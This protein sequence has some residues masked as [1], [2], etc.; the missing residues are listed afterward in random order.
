MK[1]ATMALLALAIPTTALAGAAEPEFAGWAEAPG[2]NGGTSFTAPGNAALVIAA[3]R[4]STE[5]QD[6]VLARWAGQFSSPQLCPALAAA[7]PQRSGDGRIVSLSSHEGTNSCAV[8]VGQ[9]AAGGYDI[10]FML[11]ADNTPVGAFAKLRA[12]ITR[13][14]GKITAAPPA[15]VASAQ[16]VGAPGNLQAALAAVPKAN[17]PI[18]LVSR[19]ATSMSGMFVYTVYRH[20]MIFANGYATDSHCYD[21]D[22]AVQSPTP[23]SLSGKPHECHVVRWR[24]AG[25]RYLFDDDDN[26]TFK[27][28]DA[29]AFLQPF[30]PGERIAV[31]LE[32]VSG[33]GSGP[34]I[35]GMVSVNSI[36]S[37]E[38]KMTTAGEIS[39]GSWTSVVVSGDGIGGGANNGR[40]PA[41]GRYLLDGFLIAIATKEGG[42]TRGFIGQVY[43]SGKR[44][45]Y[46][47]GTQYWEPDK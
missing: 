32:N 31:A 23:A 33:S 8:I 39:V 5:P 16:P 19:T 28:R 11:E 26:G 21:W 47:N 37:G 41:I 30:K 6:A 17:R 13:R 22:P 44:Y 2:Q 7:T 4:D 9:S 46:L 15:S 35:P 10:G 12:V 18:A 24:K 38:L 42:V 43:E 25:A 20:W 3:H 29:E 40:G 34:A 36:T 27:G 45:I 1:I 14:I